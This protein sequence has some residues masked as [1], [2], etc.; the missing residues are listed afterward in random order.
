MKNLDDTHVAKRNPETEDIEEM[1]EL[2]IE[3]MSQTMSLYGFNATVGR[4][5]GILFFAKE[6]MSL[7]DM[8]QAMGMSKTSVCTTI[9]TLVGA[10]AAKQVWLRGTRK[11]MYVAEK[12]FFQYFSDF[13]CNNL[14]TEVAL[15][16]AVL[17]K[18][19]PLYEKILAGESRSPTRAEAEEDFSKLLEVKRYYT[20]LDSFVKQYL[21]DLKI[22]QLP[23]PAESPDEP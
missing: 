13:F 7:D 3:A 19:L 11:D 20:W 9:K 21:E 12:N 2:V 5:C 1:R 16:F 18:V 8:S 17:D 23:N 15:N 4:L 6:P 22:L 14:R 10:K